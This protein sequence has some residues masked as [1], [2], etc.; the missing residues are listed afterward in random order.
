MLR[1]VTS[2]STKN[3]FINNKTMNI[4]MISVTFPYPPTKGGTHN[5]TFNLLEPISKNN[6]VTL[7]TQ[8]SE[9]VTQED[10]NNLRKY[11]NNL[12]VF[13]RPQNTKNDL[14]SKIK[15]LGNFLLAGTPPNVTSLYSQEMQKWIDNAVNE[16]KFEVVTCEHSVNEI[17]IKPEWNKKINTVINV[18][19][20]LY[21]TCKNQLETNTSDHKIRDTIYLPLLRR[22]EQKTIRKFSGVVV[23][24]DED[25][26]QM[27]LYD[28]NAMVAIVPNGVDLEMF[29]YRKSDPGGHNLVFV[30]GLDYFVNIDAVRF[31]S[32]EV[33]PLIQAKYPNS[34]LT[35]VGSK[36][37]SEVLEL[38]Q[39]PAITVT[40]RVPSV[41]EFLHKAT[42]AIAPLRTGFGMKIKTLEFLASGCPVVASDR[43]LE[44]INAENI[45]LR[46][47]RIEEYVEAIS[48]LFEDEKL[49]E[50]LSK[51]GRKL[52]EKEYIWENLA[53]N[54][55]EI[56][57]DFSS[58]KD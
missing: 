18:H 3:H 49:R 11:V 13:D 29:P 10:I 56:L 28:A 44:G 9:D 45:A 36:P 7:I 31:F 32:L 23:T 46:A 12:V 6:Q 14:L 22:Y 2:T 54:Y 42:V 41:I 24:T 4:L 38:A 58:Q 17:Y 47:N 48:K 35:L 20:S 15:R 52:I 34:T 25:Q 33:F 27:Q 21:K 57:S 1:F 37:A 8:K 5:R 39:N 50:K 19:S 43:G 53:K 51:N 55:E 30:G 26:A 16:G 40:G